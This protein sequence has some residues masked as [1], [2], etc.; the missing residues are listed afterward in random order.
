MTEVAIVVRF[1]AQDQSEAQAV[2]EALHE[3]LN[4]LH[5]EAWMCTKE[6][7]EILNKTLTELGWPVQK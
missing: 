6:S 5:S 3:V 7:L 4:A 1:T 2:L